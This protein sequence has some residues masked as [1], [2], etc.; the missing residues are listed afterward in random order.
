MVHRITEY[1]VR[2]R[3]IVDQNNSEY[4]HSSRS[5]NHQSFQSFKI[6]S[7]KKQRPVSVDSFFLKTKLI[8]I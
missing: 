6:L 7:F 8:V 4:G 3:E 5:A 1:S 2:I